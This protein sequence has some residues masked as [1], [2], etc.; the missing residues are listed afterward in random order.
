MEHDLTRASQTC[1]RVSRSKSLTQQV[2]LTKQGHSMDPS[3][4]RE[5]IDW[6]S[7][8]KHC[9]P[10]GVS[11]GPLWYQHRQ[12]G[13]KTR[14]NNATKWPA[15]RFVEGRKGRQSKHSKKAMEADGDGTA[16]KAKESANVS[17]TM[18]MKKDYAFAWFPDCGSASDCFTD[19][20]STFSYSPCP[21]FT[22]NDTRFTLTD[23]SSAAIMFQ[24]PTANT[25]L[26]VAELVDK[27]SNGSFHALVIGGPNAPGSHRHK[28]G[29][30]NCR[31]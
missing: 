23:D 27:L 22:V 13:W 16:L 19:T 20:D 21:V 17:S 6:K 28:N 15:T 1:A 24:R 10:A 7:T 11:H 26:L 18:I 9:C 25:A 8:S 31:G 29:T 30:T 14:K 3:N 2:E 5:A 12:V 4:E